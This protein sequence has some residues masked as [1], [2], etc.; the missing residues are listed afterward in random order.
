MG[1]S[2]VLA[3]P[4]VPSAVKHRPADVVPQPPVVKYEVANRLR[5]LGPLPPALEAPCVVALA[6]RRARTCGLDRVGDRTELVRGDVRDDPGLAGSVRG[7][8]RCPM[9]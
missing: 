2:A 7:V 3:S 8:P 1:A 6:L 4:G 9:Q 5:E